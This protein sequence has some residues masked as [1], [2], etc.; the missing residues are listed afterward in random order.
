MMASVI[1]VVG[2]IGMI[3]GITVGSEMMMTARR[4]AMAT[5]ILSNEI[6]RLRLE[7]WSTV[8]GLATGTTWS[9]ATAYAVGALVTYQ[10][11]SFICV[12]ANT[13]QT[14]GVSAA[15]SA[16]MTYVATTAYSKT[17]LVSFNGTWYRCT[18][19]TTAGIDPSTAAYWTAYTG[20][21]GATGVSVG[22]TFTITHTAASID[23]DSD[24]VTDL[25]ELTFIVTW[26]K[27]GTTTAA[28][29]ASGSWLNQLSFSGSAPI[30]R[31]YVRK[32]TTYF[33]KY[34]LNL[35]YQRS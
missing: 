20:P 8:S 9:S 27:S 11:G 29:V 25:K 5:Q 14:P 21:A 18:A 31:T 10:G 6:E 4:Q 32:T 2:F 1:L 22:T 16:Y 24:G 23:I 35:T 34:G 26:T 15:W 19:T 30:S 3:Q 28:A 12:T 17:D 7:S 33:G 13:N